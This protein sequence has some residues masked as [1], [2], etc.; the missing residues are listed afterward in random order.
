MMFESARFKL[1]IYYLL[2]I[3][4]ISAFFS[5]IIY[6]GASRMFE[7]GFRNMEMKM[8][9]REKGIEIPGRLPK[10]FEELP[11]RIRDLKLEY[12]KQEL[13]SARRNLRQRLF[14][15]NFCIWI[16]FGGLS[17]L[18]A[19]ETLEPI[20]E[21]LEKQKKF[22][23]DA[24]HEL[25]TPITSLL[26]STEVGLRDK[27]LTISKAKKL[28]KNN[29]E[30]IE[31]L[32]NLT[33]RLLSLAQYDSDGSKFK[34]KKVNLEKIVKK[35]IKKI[36]PMAD[37]KKIKINAKYAKKEGAKYA[38]VEI[39]GDEEKLVE[40]MTIFLDNAVKFNKKNGKI[41]VEI[42]KR[43]KKVVIKIKDTGIGIAKKELPYI[44][45]R[46]YRTDESRKRNGKDGFGLGL[47]LAKEIVEYH[48]GSIDV[49]SEPKKGTVFTISLPF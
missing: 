41:I 12:Y 13:I 24:S 2:I 14:F 45:N 18:L 7:Q 44:F 23:G 28:L 1:S 38:K 48:R 43:D 25:K 9:A 49:Q 3:M 30:E 34:F 36:K 37:K 47:S 16:V 46:F 26:T 22:I 11:E 10:R 35:A 19:G 4:L 33:N 40:M 17:Y 20:E 6:F 32:K 42:E 29:L 8:E 21:A 27:K 31:G 39:L 15:I 5:V